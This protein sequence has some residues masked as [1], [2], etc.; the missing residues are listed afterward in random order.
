MTGVDTSK[1]TEFLPSLL[2]R[3]IGKTLK[4][5]FGIDWYKEAVNSLVYPNFFIYCV[6][7]QTQSENFFYYLSQFT[8]NI[9][10]RHT[11]DIA[12]TKGV[13]EILDNMAQAISSA[14]DVIML[15]DK[16]GTYPDRFVYT[17]TDNTLE[18]VMNVSV[19]LNR[20]QVRILMQTLDLVFDNSKKE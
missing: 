5:K 6:T 3:A 12:D 18:C 4:D 14:L 8:F 1:L 7:Q 11:E 2:K 16:L 19:K 9:K 13:N 15:T 17:K 20:P 10:Y